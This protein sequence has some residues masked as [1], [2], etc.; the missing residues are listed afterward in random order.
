[1]TMSGS[2]ADSAA[3]LSCI[4]GMWSTGTWSASEIENFVRTATVVLLG[5]NSTDF[6]AAVAARRRDMKVTTI[7]ERA[8]K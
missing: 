4:D 8:P 2:L 3:H 7:R 1:M 6:E 5:S